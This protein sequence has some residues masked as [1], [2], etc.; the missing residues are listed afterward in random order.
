MAIP[1]G[2]RM[3]MNQVLGASASDFICDQIDEG[4]DFLD[5]EVMYFGTGNDASISYDGTNWVFN[6]QVVGSGVYQLTGGNV[7]AVGLAIN[8]ATEGSTGRLTIQTAQE[9]VD[10]SSGTSADS[11]IAIPSGAVLL[12]VSFCVNTAVT[13]DDG[14]DTW[15]AAFITGSTT[16]L[17]SA[18]AAAKNTKVNTLIVPEVASD[19]T[20]VQFTPNG[21]NF[22]AGAIEIVAYYYAL[23]SLAD[24]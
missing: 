17:A 13:D 14:D 16:S 11:T 19:A 2:V 1:D 23:T 21:T 6:S 20:E 5:D 10:V 18:A 15:S 4:G 24:A 9:V 22:T 3:K 12:G 7:E 8:N